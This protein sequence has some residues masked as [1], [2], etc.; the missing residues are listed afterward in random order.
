MQC[1][2]VFMYF[3]PSHNGLGVSTL[4][5]LYCCWE[6]KVHVVSFCLLQYKKPKGIV[7][8]EKSIQ[9]ELKKLKAEKEGDVECNQS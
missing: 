7:E 2:T 3:C 8:M 6:D 9:M 5:V 1:F 4:C